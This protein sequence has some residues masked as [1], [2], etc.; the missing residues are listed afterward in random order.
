M[1]T[2]NRCRLIKPCSEFHAGA[3]KDGR[4]Y[5]CKSCS[6]ELAHIWYENQLKP[7]RR[8]KVRAWRENNPEA[9]AA[10][11]WSSKLKRHG[12]TPDQYAKIL[13]DQQGLCAIC[14][15]PET[16]IVRGTLCAM[17]IDHDHKCCSGPFS[18]GKCVRGLLCDQCNKALGC[19]NDN[20]S[21]L[22]RAAEY[23][24]RR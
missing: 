3:S 6:A 20:P 11:Q 13:T 12:L 9:Q 16:R 17:A 22:R 19:F 10:I 5:R 23:L 15:N 7:A 24:E 1:K 14:R 8:E 21:R 18:C 4:A 2:C